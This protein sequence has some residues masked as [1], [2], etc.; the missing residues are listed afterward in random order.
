MHSCLT[1]RLAAPRP[2]IFAATPPPCTSFYIYI[3]IQPDSLLLYRYRHQ[4]GNHLCEIYVNSLSSQPNILLLTF[5]D[6]ELLQIR[7]R[8]HRNRHYV[9]TTSRSSIY[10]VLQ[11]QKLKSLNNITCLKLEQLQ[12]I[13]PVHFRMWNRNS[14][15]KRRRRKGGARKVKKIK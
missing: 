3:Y 8:R 6:A 5:Y 1:Y 14:T 4:D 13:I 7:D 11:K 15:F 12:W 2:P 9:N 10:A